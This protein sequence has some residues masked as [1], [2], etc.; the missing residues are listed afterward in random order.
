MSPQAAKERSIGTKASGR[1]NDEIVEVDEN[2][3]NDE[4]GENEMAGGDG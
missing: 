4:N 2:D 1:K 3:E